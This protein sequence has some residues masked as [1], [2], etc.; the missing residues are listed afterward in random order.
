[1]WNKF[2]GEFE[3]NIE[4]LLFIVENLYTCK[5][6]TF[7]LN[8]HKERA[9]AKTKDQSISMWLEINLRKNTDFKNPLYD[10]TKA[11]VRITRIPKPDYYQ[12]RVW[13]EYYFRFTE[14]SGESVSYKMDSCE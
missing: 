9:D 13:R 4:M 12:L 11:G 6:G 7:L 1:M 14:Q 5:Y 2:P 8:S 10:P 3:F